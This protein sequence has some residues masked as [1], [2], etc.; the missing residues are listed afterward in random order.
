LFG[1][2]LTAYDFNNDGRFD[3]AVGI[4]QEDLGAISDAGMVALLYGSSSGLS[5][6]VIPDQTWEQNTL[7]IEDSNEI[8]DRYGIALG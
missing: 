8:N 5:A 4:P 2:A 6:R 1:S 3:L 7:S